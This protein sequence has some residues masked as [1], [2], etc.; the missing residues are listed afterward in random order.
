[1]NIPTSITIDRLWINHDESLL[2][3]KSL[4]VCASIE[5]IC[6]SVAPV[7]SD[8]NRRVCNQILRDVEPGSYR[9]WI[10][11]EIGDFSIGRTWE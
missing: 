11:P 3:C 7:N 6:V 10:A 2:V 1:M 8:N 9:G 4:E 5:G